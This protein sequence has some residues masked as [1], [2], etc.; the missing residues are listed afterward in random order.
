VGATTVTVTGIQ[1]I[2]V[3]SPPVEPNDGDTFFYSA[4]N[5]EWYYSSPWEIPDG[6]DLTFEGPYGYSPVG[7]SWLASD[8]LAVGDGTP[9]DVSGAMAMTGLIL[10]GAANY[11]P[12]PYDYD[13]DYGSP[14]DQYYTTLYSGATQDW[15]MVLPSGPGLPGQLL[16]TNGEGMTYW[17]TEGGSSSFFYTVTSQTSNYSAK[18]GDD[19]WCIGTFMVMLPVLSTTQR[20]KVNNRGTGTITVVPTSGT[21]NGDSSVTIARQYDSAEFAGDGTNIGVE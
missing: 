5:N 14:Y 12:G 9:G 2:P 19:V 6:Q 21:I 17:T 16:A 11:G 10:F 3:V 8:T 1:Q 20:V 15:S 7:L 13:P 18:S 4:Y